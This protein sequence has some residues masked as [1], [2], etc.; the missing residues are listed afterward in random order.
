M[1]ENYKSRVLYLQ[2]TPKE[3]S[4]EGLEIVLLKFLCEVF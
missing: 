3:L 4:E 1:N 2:V